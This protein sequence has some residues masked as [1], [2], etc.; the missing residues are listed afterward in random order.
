MH[1]MRAL[2]GH[3][4]T[5]EAVTAM[6]ATSYPAKAIGQGFAIFPL[7]ELPECLAEWVW[8]DIEDS[9]V[10]AQVSTAFKDLLDQVASAVITGSLAVVIT[11]YWAGEGTQFAA[12]VRDGC[13][14]L[15]PVLG[16]GSINRSL[17]AIGVVPRDGDAFDTLMLGSWRSMDD[18]VEECV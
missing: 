16:E 9:A 14:V 17:E 8:P 1:E 7:V 4:D 12:V 5:I 11:Q 3:Q 18:L 2:I 13:V 15:G 6:W 10:A